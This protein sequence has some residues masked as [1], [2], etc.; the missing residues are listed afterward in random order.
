M[1]SQRL[2]GKERLARPAHLGDTAQRRG[3]GESASRQHQEGRRERRAIRVLPH[4]LPVQF[5]AGRAY[6]QGRS[7]DGMSRGAVYFAR[8]SA[9][10]T[11]IGICTLC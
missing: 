2:Q 8:A 7:T 4:L 1:A 9:C 5:R 6:P 10:A 11:E 3:L